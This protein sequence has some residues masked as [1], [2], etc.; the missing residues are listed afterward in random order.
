MPVKK[1][2][3]D[4]MTLLTHLNDLTPYNLKRLGIYISETHTFYHRDGLHARLLWCGV[5][6]AL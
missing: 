3:S 5:Q 1:C 2:L 6:A 4:T